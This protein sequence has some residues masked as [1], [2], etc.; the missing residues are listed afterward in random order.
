[1]NPLAP[2]TINLGII[3]LGHAGRQQLRATSSIASINVVALAEVS[4]HPDL[5]ERRD[6]P[7]YQDWHELLTDPA[8]GAVSICLPHY[9]HAEVAIAALRAGK[10]V[11]LEKPLASSLEEAQRIVEAARVAGRVLMVEMTHHF[12][13]PLRAGRDLIQS[14]RLGH[15]YAVE[16]RIIEAIP[17]GRLPPWMLQRQFAGGGVALTN[18]IHMLDRI[19]WMCGQPLRFHSGVAGWTYQLGDI[20]DTAAM[21]LS[22]AD[23]TPVAFLAAWPHGSGLDD[24]LTIYGSEGT[25]RIWA[26]RGWRFEPIQPNAGEAEEHTGYRPD[27]DRAARARIGMSGALAEFAGAIAEGRTPDPAPEQVLAAQAIV[28]EFY[29]HVSVKDV[30]VKAQS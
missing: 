25:L 13:P 26:W 18:G 16:D 28:E 22:L 27:D 8:I 15:I 20:E 3:G 23:G 17:P 12:Y 11:L 2:T 30:G 24:E 4:P 10:H 14:G 6:I 9:L 19:T 21:Q 5:V 1:M 7:L 29:R